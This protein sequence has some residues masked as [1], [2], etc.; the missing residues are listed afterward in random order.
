MHGWVRGKRRGEGMPYT[1]AARG[2]RSSAVQVLFLAPSTSQRCFVM[3]LGY[4]Q[5]EEGSTT[6]EG[7]D[8]VIVLNP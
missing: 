4:K 6:L 8:V 1:S 7:M 3:C 5:I 2:A